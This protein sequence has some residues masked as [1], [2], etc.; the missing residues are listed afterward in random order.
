[1]RLRFVLN[2]VVI[3]LA[4]SPA[5]A[6]VA[7]HPLFTDHM[8]PQRTTPIPVWGPAEPGESTSGRLQRRTPEWIES[9]V[10]ETV[11]DSSGAWKALLP[12][13]FTFGPYTMTV[14]GKNKLT[15]SDVLIGE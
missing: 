15:L 1:M 2:F 7:L 3:T 14:E 8:V 5:R 9:N 10:A 12:L 4:V 13:P 6:D 11:A